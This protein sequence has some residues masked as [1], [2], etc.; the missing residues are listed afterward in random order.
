MTDIIKITSFP[1]E[2]WIGIVYVIIGITFLTF[3][4]NMYAIKRVSPNIATT[5]IFLQPFLSA[6]LSLIINGRLMDVWSI[7][8]SV[9]I[10]IGVYFVSFKK[11]KKNQISEEI[12]DKTD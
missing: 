3:L 7:A 10:F 4:L 6:I 12:L 9:L 5:Y 1:T 2:I 8:A 11:E